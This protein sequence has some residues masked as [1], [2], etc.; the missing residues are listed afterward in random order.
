MLK[1]SKLIAILLS[2]ILTITL[3]G[4]MPVYETE[5][6]DNPVTPTLYGPYSGERVVD[7]DTIIIDL[8]GERTRVRFL[9]VDTPESVA[10]DEERNTEEGVVASDYTKELLPKGSLVYLEYDIVRTDKY[11]RVLAYVYLDDQETMIERKLLTDGMAKVYND[12]DN[13]LYYDEFCKLEQAAQNS[14]I[15]IWAE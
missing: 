5:N 13:K 3:T 11:D 14:H 15:G 7:G 4:C 9:G 6:N 12:R 10:P 2:L 1:Q 8:D